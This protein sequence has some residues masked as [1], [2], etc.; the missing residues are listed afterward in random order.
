MNEEGKWDKFTN[1]YSLQKT[2]QFEL[3][4][5]GRTLEHIENNGLIDQ[6]EKRA[7]S[8]K[9]MKNT[10]N[11]F[12]K[13][14]IQIAMSQVK[15]TK[16]KRFADLYNAPPERKK[17]DRFKEEFKKTK[18]DL[19]KEIVKGFETGKAGDIFSKMFKKELFTE[20][21][22][23]WISE[24]KKEIIKDLNEWNKKSKD[25]KK[26][27]VFFDEDFKKFTVYFQ[28]FNENRKNMYTDKD[29][30]TAIAYRLIHENLPKF[31]DNVNAFKKIKP[32]PELYKKCTSLYKE[33]KEYLNIKNIDEVFEL[34][35]YNK[36]LT[37]E[38]I[39]SYNLIIGGMTVQKGKNKIQGLN[40]YINLYNQKHDK[41][42]KLKQLY[43]QIL[44]DKESVSFLP[45]AFKDAQELLDAI[46]E[47]YQSNLISFQPDGTDSAENVLKKIKE[48]LEN[49][50]NYDTKKVYISNDTTITDIS[51]RLFG[52]RGIIKDALEFSFPQTLEIDK[53][54][55]SKKQEKE[56]ENYL[57]Q[58]YFSIAEIEE[59]LSAYKNEAE[60]LNDL[61]KN[62]VADYFHTHFL[63][64]KKEGSDKEFDLIANIQAKYSCIK[65]ILNT[66]YPK[67]KRLYQDKKTIGDIKGFLDSLKELLHF[68]KPL[69]LPSDSTLEKDEV[70]YSQFQPWF[71]Q[72]QLLP[73]LYN[74]VRDYAS[75]KPYSIEK[76]K[77]NFENSTLLAGWDVNKEED[78]TAILLEKEG[79]YFLGIM[80][81]KYN[82][83]FRDIP[84]APKSSD[85]FQKIN[86]KLLPGASKML[87]KVFFSEKN[88]GFYAPTKEILRIRNQGSYTK[89]GNPQPGFKKSKFNISDC[90]KMISFF[91]ESI[92]KHP[93]WKNFGF[94][95]SQTETY[96]SIDE[97][98][99]EVESQG[100]SI[101]HTPIE[102]KLLMKYV[103]E[104]KF[105]LFQIYNKDFSEHSKGTPNLHT[106]YWKAI[107]D[108]EN[109]KNVIYKLNGGAEMF[110]RKKSITKSTIHK[111]N[112]PIKNKN[113][114]NQKK[115]SV[116]GYDL[117]KDRRYT[118]DKFQFHV[119]ITL[120]FKATGVGRIN[121]NVLKFLKD[122]S[123][124]NIIGLDR[125]ERHLIY[126]TLIDQ[127]GNILEQRSLNT[128]ISNEFNT[129]TDYHELLDNR[130][131]ERDTARKDWGTIE[132][133]KELKEGYI[134]VIV[135]EI[136]KMMIKHNAIVVMEDLNFG[137]KRGRF[138]IEKQVYQK[139]EEKLI[140]KL[141]YLILKEKE[142]YETSGLYKALQL[143]NKFESFKKLG[144]Q[145]GFLFYVPPE[146]TSKIDPTT[147]FVNLFKTKYENVN[148]AKTFF[149]N[150]ENISYNADKDYFEFEVKEYSLFN[151]KA[152]NTRQEWVICTN[153]SRIK[154]FKNSNKNNHW[155][156][157]EIVL[158][159]E[160]KKLFKEYGIEYKEDLKNGILSQ[161][162]KTF[163]EKLLNLFKYTVQM[164]NSITNSET[165]YLIS[166]VM[167]N[168]G[169]FYDS[170]KAGDDLPKDAD[171]NG[172]YHIAKKGLWVLNQINAY[173]GADWKKLKLAISIK[174]WLQFAQARGE[175]DNGAKHNNIKPQ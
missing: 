169:E 93:E 14:F 122:N 161:N 10:I 56:K 58:S 120:N 152:D 97:F 31:L 175:G 22:G 160:F 82:K 63:A 102:K 100:Y 84:S 30:S 132:T 5:I 17:E 149:K 107:F 144:K 105:Y 143:T 98:Y 89:N 62:V 28:G 168:K 139:L 23:E 154:N 16:L 43:K 106:M 78:N 147:G 158:S 2:L 86:Y 65:G 77:L 166:P 8:F 26:D 131:K 83:Q 50:E 75:Q 21:L 40:E 124:V 73:S 118:V 165:D 36:L 55:S 72:L 18:D 135:H 11:G 113:P 48:L 71:D 159:D 101:S 171:A 85:V 32:I 164:R 19:R 27:L 34:E 119:P 87:P 138:K 167:N 110:Y 130:E 121:N 163:F 126:L 20:L 6:D 37:Q 47:Y 92:Q 15:L 150:F 66:P 151:S 153:G 49:L 35:Y 88:I 170:R 33:I 69:S 38:Q 41:K 104:G 44:S 129:K 90:Q 174:E 7:E 74:K 127:K 141:N 96:K 76:L 13:Y 162:E 80:D 156:N 103:D 12:H 173:E 172:A 116:F 42:P 91:K 94:K 46:E 134:S 70:F 3:K 95:F 142:N 81:K 68:V 125:G 137:F 54:G 145:S 67:E 108:P 1:L 123:G 60:V 148:K 59:A 64:K 133:I 39:D 9:E 115:E 29:Q 140:K 112:E 4:P 79:D 157:E 109:L 53:K 155:D 114:N 24:S 45:G 57:K 111:A 99:R 128:I 25:E 146:Y 61:Q 117:V 52:D 136:S 51:K